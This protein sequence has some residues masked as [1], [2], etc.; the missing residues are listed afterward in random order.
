MPHN[1]IE[2]INPAAIESEFADSLLNSGARNTEAKNTKAMSRET[3]DTT[4][5][6]FGE[7]S[8]CVHY[9]IPKKAVNFIYE[10]ENQKRKNR[11]RG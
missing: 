6:L 9:I 10:K 2:S 5:H 8:I 11:K 4:F 7:I 3:S 1:I